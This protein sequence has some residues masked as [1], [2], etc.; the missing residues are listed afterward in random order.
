LFALLLCAATASCG[1]DHDDGNADGAAG[2]GAGGAAGGG[3]GGAAADAAAATGGVS[4]SDGRPASDSGPGGDAPVGNEAGLPPLDAIADAPSIT[5]D[6]MAGVDAAED[7]PSNPGPDAAPPGAGC[8]LCPNGHKWCNG[9]CVSPTDPLLGCGKV[10]YPCTFANA[11]GVCDAQGRCTRGACRPGWGD[12]NGDPADGCEADLTDGNNCGACGVKCPAVCAPGGCA[13]ACPV[14]LTMCGTRC[15]DLATSTEACGAC[16]P[17]RKVVN[18]SIACAAGTCGP[19]VCN[20]GLSECPSSPGSRI[21][22]CVDL[23]NDPANCGVCGRSC[24]ALLRSPNTYRYS[25]CKAGQCVDTCPPGWTECGTQ[26][27]HLP[28]NPGHCG[29]CGHACAAGESCQSGACLAD[30]GPLLVGGLMQPEDIATDGVEV[31]FSTLGDGGV[32]KVSATGGTAVP[33]A[34][35]QAKPVRIAIDRTHVYWANELGGAVMRAARDGSTP[36]EVVAPAVKPIALVL[37][38]A[39]VYW[40]EN[41]ARTMVA[42]KR[43]PKGTGGAGALLLDSGQLGPYVFDLQLSGNVLYSVGDFVVAYPLPAGPKMAV[44][45]SEV[46]PTAFAVDE[47][48]FYSSGLFGASGRHF[49]WS[50]RTGD[51]ESFGGVQGPEGPMA[52]TPCGVVSGGAS[53]KFT[54]LLPPLYLDLSHPMIP[55]L[56]AGGP[57]RRVA[58]AAGYMYWTSPG[59]AAADGGVFRLRTPM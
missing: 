50:S 51:K 45:E 20:P 42:L 18:G 56:V 17:C 12:C 28:S 59:S 37:D 44:P 16:A 19:L 27:A 9:Q 24:V 49:T 10:C 41:P 38:A 8:R 48:H 25:A 36:A 30:A 32:Y 22:V 34:T 57:A 40:I 53:L 4:G 35:G 58:Y 39:N 7:A 3:T 2:A 52:A 54:P 55:S 1:D 46:P 29:A 5:T 13:A 33:L 23:M 26:C 43:A 15:L 6:A 21:P 14:P 31:F 11:A 47:N